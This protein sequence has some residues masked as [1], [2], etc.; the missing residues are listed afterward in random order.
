MKER[1]LVSS[2]PAFQIASEALAFSLGKK[3]NHP[4]RALP[5][6]AQPPA[7]G[8]PKLQGLGVLHTN[9]PRHLM[10]PIKSDAEKSDA[11][12]A[13]SAFPAPSPGWLWTGDCGPRHTGGQAT[14]APPSPRPPAG[15]QAG[16]R[17]QTFAGTAAPEPS[18]KPSEERE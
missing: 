12:K 18:C 15:F 9:R 1:P 13:A 6:T 3:K 5:R 11:E 4:M 14:K 16:A 10:K 8:T 2:P 7:S 17:S